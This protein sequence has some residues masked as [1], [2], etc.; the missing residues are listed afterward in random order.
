MPPLLIFPLGLYVIGFGKVFKSNCIS[1]SYSL[2]MI[3]RSVLDSLYNTYVYLY[4]IVMYSVFD[5]L[6]LIVA[7]TKYHLKTVLKLFDFCFSYNE[8]TLKY[9]TILSTE[10]ANKTSSIS[11]RVKP[12]CF[13]VSTCYCSIIG[14]MNR[15]T[16]RTLI[17]CNIFFIT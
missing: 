9:V 8:C 6:S 10:I 2:L 15:F 14:N 7:Y 16:I 1:L 11:K 17:S 3:E 12:F 5:G 4:A 13:T